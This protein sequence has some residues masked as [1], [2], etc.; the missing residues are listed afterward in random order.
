MFDF[1]SIRDASPRTHTLSGCKVMRQWIAVYCEPDSAR[2]SIWMSS[3]DRVDDVSTSE[4]HD[5][6]GEVKTPNTSPINNEFPTY[7]KF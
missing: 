6:L 7:Q 5:I 2:W 4:M 3:G 1:L